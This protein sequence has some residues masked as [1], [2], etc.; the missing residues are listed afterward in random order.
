MD[1]EAWFIQKSG[2]ADWNHSSKIKPTAELKGQR[3]MAS[4]GMAF[5]CYSCLS[6]HSF[7]FKIPPPLPDWTEG[8]QGIPSYMDIFCII[9]AVLL[10][11]GGIIRWHKYPWI[12]KG[13]NTE[14]NK[15]NHNSKNVFLV[16]IGKD[17]LFLYIS[18][19]LGSMLAVPKYCE[20]DYISVPDKCRK[21]HKSIESQLYNFPILQFSRLKKVG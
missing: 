14:R 15:L 1:C 6:A 17:C 11:F 4:T 3:E 16:V 8:S 12:T 21:Y 2:N 9:P 18:L 13:Q 7:L 20:M 19:L 10:I 5:S